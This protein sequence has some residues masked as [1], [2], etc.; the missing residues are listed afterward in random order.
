LEDW[1]KTG[2]TVA[3]FSRS[4]VDRRYVDPRSIARR[5]FP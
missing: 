3:A 2:S 5:G 1:T 4:R